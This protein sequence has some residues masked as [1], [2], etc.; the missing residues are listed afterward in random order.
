M[1]SSTRLAAYRYG[2]RA[3][4][5]CVIFL[6]VRGYHIIAR[7]MRNSGGEID[8][9]AMRRHQLVFIEV[10]ARQSRDEGLYALSPKQQQRIIHAAKIWLAEHTKYAGRDAR[11][12]LMVVHRWRVH[13]LRHAFELS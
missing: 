2:L 10:K 7:R 12:D 11:F 3:E 1:T 13:Q 4:T 9:I 6:W 5:R 8:L